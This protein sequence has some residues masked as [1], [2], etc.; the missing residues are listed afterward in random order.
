MSATAVLARPTSKRAPSRRLKRLPVQALLEWAFMRE[1]VRLEWFDERPVEERG[2][3]YGI[4]YVLLRRAQLGC[5][6]DGGGESPRHDDAELV[7]AIVAGIPPEQGGRRMALLVA[8][9]ART[10]L[11]MDWMPG[12]VPQVVPREWKRTKHGPRAA[13]RVVGVERVRTRGRWREVEVRMCPIT[14]DPSPQQIESARDAY[15]RWRTALGWVRDAIRAS[16]M[17]RDHELL[18]A[19]PVDR[20]W[21]RRPGS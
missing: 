12:A 11:T 6:V 15:T 13:T 20:P 3:G 7:A 1:K 21:E 19:L 14:F 17:L 9:L 8:E 2:F 18:E 16:R 5:R 4:E 10:G